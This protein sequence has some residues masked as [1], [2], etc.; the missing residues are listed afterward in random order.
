MA[1]TSNQDENRNDNVFQILSLDGG[2]IRG[3]FSAA[4]LDYFEKHL[5]KK[6][7]NGIIDHFDLITGTSTGGIIA[8]GL[9]IGL[10]PREI[11]EFYKHYGDKIFT[12]TWGRGYLSPYA[13]YSSEPLE[14]ALIDK[15]D[16]K[17]LKDCSKRLVVPAYNIDNDN[18]EVDESFLFKTPHS[19]TCGRDYSTQLWQIGLATSSAPTYFPVCKKI[20]NSRLIDGG[21]WA[22]NPILIGIS[23]ATKIMEEK[24]RDKNSYTIRVLSLGTGKTINN[25]SEKIEDSGISY[26]APSLIDIFMTAQ[27]TSANHYAGYWIGKENILRIDPVLS[28]NVP[29]DSSPKS[30]K[31]TRLLSQVDGLGKSFLNRFK[32]MFTGH[33]APEYNPYEH[34]EGKK[35]RKLA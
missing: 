28:Q 29:L 9:S 12:S 15:F 25:F 30:D 32:E 14:K 21:M 19:V 13:K 31:V 1:N 16:Q 4:L 35:P 18:K 5:C 11:V 3:I 2:G 22:N 34:Q 24:K 20:K 17:T 33:I 7:G 8:L 27:N 6:N 23:E 26:W 10:R